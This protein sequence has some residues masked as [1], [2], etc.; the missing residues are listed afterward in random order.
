MTPSIPPTKKKQT[1]KLVTAAAI[2]VHPTIKWK[3]V[4]DNLSDSCQERHIS[5]LDFMAA[6]PLWS[7]KRGLEKGGVFAVHIRGLPVGAYPQE[8]LR[9]GRRLV[10]D[11]QVKLEQT[12]TPYDK[13]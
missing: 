4:R 5:W 2:S 11:Q 6:D 13:N 7:G 3:N 8:R 10:L 1:A 9:I 12:N